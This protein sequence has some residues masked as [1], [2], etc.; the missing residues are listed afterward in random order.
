MSRNEERNRLCLTVLAVLAAVFLLACGAGGT[1]E[2]AGPDREAR[3][4]AAARA[5]TPDSAGIKVVT[6]M[7]ATQGSP[8][9]QIPAAPPAPARRADITFGSDPSATPVGEPDDAGP[10]GEPSAPWEDPEPPLRDATGARI[11]SNRDLA[12]YREVKEEF[13]FRD[14]VVTVDL[15]KP[16]AVEGEEKKTESGMTTAQ[17]RAERQSITDRIRILTGEQDQLARRIP[18]L[19]NPLLPRVQAAEADRMAESGMDNAEKLQHIN[20]RLNAIRSEL[21]SLQRRY[22]ELQ[23]TQPTDV[24]GP[25][26]GGTGRD[27]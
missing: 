27:E 13:G 20:T 18:S 11:Y 2:S 24:K 17:I 3:I 26:D 1:D 14:G 16:T 7:P 22:A 5:R 21:S 25:T 6:A 8:A 10:D 12:K 19:H 15:T 23:N 4:A 9:P